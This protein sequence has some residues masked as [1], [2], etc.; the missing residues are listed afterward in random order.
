MWIIVNINPTNMP[1][2][3]ALPTTNNISSY[4]VLF[5]INYHSGLSIATHWIEQSMHDYLIQY[6]GSQS[7]HYCWCYTYSNG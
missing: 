1:G 3:L 5:I 2:S 6:L 4:M 7:K